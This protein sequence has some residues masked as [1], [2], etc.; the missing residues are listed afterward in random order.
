MV[1]NKAD[2]LL[3][4]FIFKRMDVLNHDL[5]HLIQ[6]SLIKKFNTL[7]FNLKASKMSTHFIL[8]T[9][10]CWPVVNSVGLKDCWNYRAEPYH[11][12]RT[13][14]ILDKRN[15]F[16]LGFSFPTVEGNNHF[17]PPWPFGRKRYAVSFSERTHY[18]KD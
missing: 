8:C 7:Y 5:I 15:S 14:N 11:R 3:V 16:T 1:S 2:T 9:S 10:Q 13:L 6:S 17:N 12:K 4:E 18:K